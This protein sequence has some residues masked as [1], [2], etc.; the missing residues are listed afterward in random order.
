MLRTLVR[1][2]VLAALLL[3]IWV[4]SIGAQT[5][6]G[7]V[8]GRV[9]D[10]VT[11]APLPGAEVTIDGT[12]LKT[13][14]DRDGDFRI[15]GVPVG[16]KTVVI[17]YLGRE[18]TKATIEVTSGGTAVAAVTVAA[19]QRYVESVTVS[20]LQ[21]DAQARALNQQKTA[22]NIQNIIS[23]DQIGTFPDPNAAET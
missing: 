8:T 17:T 3:A 2:D 5:P 7:V 12:Q 1:R 6:T 4:P 15:A 19:E 13:S 14:T 9:I 16:T 20:A 21:A 10:G 11:K 22:L 23:A 18:T